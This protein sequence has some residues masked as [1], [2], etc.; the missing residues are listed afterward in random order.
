[1]L[2]T[3]AVGAV[4]AALVVAIGAGMALYLGSANQFAPP[5]WGGDASGARFRLR[6]HV[7]T[8]APAG[9]VGTATAPRHQCLQLTGGDILPPNG[10][11]TYTLDVGPCAPTLPAAQFAFGKAGLVNASAGVRLNEE[12]IGGATM[13]AMTGDA[14]RT[15]TLQMRR[16][17]PAGPSAVMFA[18]PGANG[19]TTAVLTVSAATGGVQWSTLPA[20]SAPPA[21]ALFTVEPTRR[22]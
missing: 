16:Y 10:I 17:A 13:M 2:R 5:P 8:Q 18:V 3:L 11:L 12:H 7:S 22:G 21:S 1:M 6:S 15:G 4:A 19:D 14:P 9:A 20:G